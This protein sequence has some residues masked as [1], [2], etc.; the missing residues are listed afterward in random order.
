VQHRL[1]LIDKHH[2]LTELADRCLGIHLHDVDGLKDHQPPGQG[3]ADW[4]YVR[5][6]LPPT[7]LR[8]C[9]INQHT[10]EEQVA[11]AIPYLREQGI[12]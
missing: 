7:A 12:L 1:Q 2:W 6:Y 4:E 10:P 3:T 9:E 11:T 8:V 5:R